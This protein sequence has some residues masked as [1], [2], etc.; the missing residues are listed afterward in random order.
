M[1]RKMWIIGRIGWEY[2]D[3]NYYRGDDQGVSPIKAF[4]FPELAKEHCNE[5][6]VKEF[7]TLFCSNDKYGRHIGDWMRDG[8]SDEAQEYLKGI[9]FKL[10]KYGEIEEMAEITDEQVSQ[11]MEHLNLAWYE[12]TE[13]DLEA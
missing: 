9:G 4:T 3:Q 13:V 7:R 12:L 5:L 10:G 1:S 8:M 2:D 6:N 11:I